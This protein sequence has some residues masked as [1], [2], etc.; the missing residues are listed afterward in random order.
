MIA[1]FAEAEVATLVR[2][3]AAPDLDRDAVVDRFARARWS[4]IAE[5]GE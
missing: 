2:A 4:G 3:V 1:G 5:P